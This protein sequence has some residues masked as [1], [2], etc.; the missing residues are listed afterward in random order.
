MFSKNKLPKLCCLSVALCLIT[1]S[2]HAIVDMNNNNIDD[3]YEQIFGITFDGSAPGLLSTEDLDGD[4]YTNEQES[5]FGTAPDDSS[6]FFDASTAP[7]RM[8]QSFTFNP[9]TDEYVIEYYGIFGKAYQLKSSAENLNLAVDSTIYVGSDALETLTITADLANVKSEFFALQVSDMNSDT[10]DLTDWAE[11]RLGTNPLS[12]FSD[13]DSLPDDWEFIRGTD[14]LDAT[15]INGDLGN[16]D[17]DAYDNITEFNAWE[18]IPPA[19]MNLQTQNVSAASIELMWSAVDVAPGITGYDI[20]RDGEK[21]G[22]VSGTT[23]TDMDFPLPTNDG[24]DIEYAVIAVTKANIASAMSSSVSER[25]GDIEVLDLGNVF[26][27]FPSAPVSSSVSFAV[28]PQTVQALT[29]PSVTIRYK[30]IIAKNQGGYRISKM[31]DLA[32][33]EEEQWYGQ[34]TE[35]LDREYSNVSTLSGCAPFF[36]SQTII[37]ELDAEHD[38]MLGKNLFGMTNTIETFDGSTTEDLR[39]YTDPEE[40]RLWLSL[41]FGSNPPSNIDNDLLIARY[42]AFSMDDF[43]SLEETDIINPE[44]RILI[45][46]GMETSSF[47]FFDD[48]FCQ[49]FVTDTFT[50]NADMDY[51][52]EYRELLTEEARATRA[53]EFMTDEMWDSIEWGERLESHNG[54]YWMEITP[55]PSNEI[56]IFAL[57]VGDTTD[58]I[59]PADNTL[60]EAVPFLTATSLQYEFELNGAEPRTRYRLS[61][62]EALSDQTA[63][64]VQFLSTPQFAM[65]GDLTSEPVAVAKETDV[66]S[67]PAGTPSLSETQTTEPFTEIGEGALLNIRVTAED[68]GGNNVAANPNGVFTPEFNTTSPNFTPP[69]PGNILFSSY[70]AQTVF[71]SCLVVY[72]KDVIEEV[73]NVWQLKDFDIKFEIELPSNLSSASVLWEFVDGPSGSGTLINSNQTQAIFRNPT[74]GGLYNFDLTINGNFRTRIQVWLPVAGP[75][76]SHYWQ[77]EIDYF[78]NIWGPDYR[79][80]VDSLFPGFTGRTLWGQSF[81]TV[82]A[83][84]SMQYVGGVLDWIEP[85]IGTETPSGGPNFSG[86]EWRQ[87]LHGVTIDFRK[88]NNMMYALIGREMGLLETVLSNAPDL[89]GAGTP[90]SASALESYEAGYDLYDGISL[91]NIMQERGIQMQE[92]DSWADW[93]W[94]SSEFSQDGLVRNAANQLDNLLGSE[95]GDNL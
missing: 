52:A 32:P 9:I 85:V 14:P 58:P 16:I 1:W 7:G 74:K 49:D 18:N 22:N 6:I 38:F 40:L 47:T 56:P 41:F 8:S 36:F 91:Q 21:I 55:L 12:E 50:E 31:R 84:A 87:T 24:A 39:E 67:S 11:N 57:E 13:A 2:V 72:Y 30:Q 43:P 77:S 54:E 44:S 33:G 66:R 83:T 70:S 73:S 94:P 51:R 68:S 78:K 62:V 75:D 61:W 26:S 34:L 95:L 17:G 3:V 25:V 45:Q 60:S 10:D 23:Y 46:T 42:P 82:I 86:D 76:I 71:N 29:G 63:Q 19:P 27:S 53:Y 35:N 81:K 37:A 48:A 28:A 80:N 88:R 69:V 4:G 64:T 65:E 5:V 89:I 93:E 90:D 15:G 59:D 79:A 20:Y 92:T